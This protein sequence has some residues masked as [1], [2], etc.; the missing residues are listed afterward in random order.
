MGNH[1]TQTWPSRVRDE[2]MVA[3][4]AG[5]LA[6]L[7]TGVPVTF[8]GFFTSRFDGVVGLVTVAGIT[9]GLVVGLLHHYRPA[10]TAIVAA[11]VV[12]VLVGMATEPDTW[13]PFVACVAAAPV[14][15]WLAEG[16]RGSARR[17]LFGAL[18]V[19]GMLLPPVVVAEVRAQICAR[20]FL[21]RHRDAARSDIDALLVALSD[22]NVEWRSGFSHGFFTAVKLTAYWEATTAVAGKGACRLVTQWW[23]PPGGASGDYLQ[24][25]RFSF[26]PHTPARLNSAHQARRLLS[27]LGLRGPP[28]ELTAETSAGPRALWLGVHN[29][30]SLGA[31]FEVSETGGVRAEWYGREPD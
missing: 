11:S 9:G 2:P 7:V 27:D 5:S 13:V 26:R 25:A 4:I 12:G 1:E 19:L 3:A 18:L 20:H 14:G 23:G 31:D 22:H 24:R 10:L 17:G 28:A 29:G 21:V 16:L 15:A 8:V 6:F 30:N